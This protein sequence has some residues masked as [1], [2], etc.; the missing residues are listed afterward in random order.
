M[1]NALNNFLT[2]ITK[3]LNMQHREKG[4]IIHILKDSFAGKF[5]SIKIIPINEAEIKNVMHSLKPK[6]PSGYDEIISKILKACPSV[7]FHLLS[8]I[9]NPWFQ[10]FTVFWI[11]YVFFG[12]FPGVRLWFADI[13]PLKMELIE[14]SETSANH[15]RTPGKYPKEY[16]QYIYNHSL[17][18]VIFPDHLKIAVVIPLYKK[19]GKA[20]MTNYK[21]ISLLAVFRRVLEKAKHCRL[22]QHLH[23]NNIL[24]TQQYD[25]R[26]GISTEDAAFRLTD[27]VFECINQKMHVRGIFYDLAKAFDFVNHEILSAILPFYGTWGV[28]KDWFRFCLTNRSQQV[29]VTSPNSTQIF[30]PWLEYTEIWSSPRINS[31]ASIVHNRCKW[32]SPENKFCTRTNIIYC[33]T[34]FIISSRNFEYFCSVLNLGLSNMIKWFAANNLVL[35]LE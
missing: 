35:N 30:F 16:I 29:E 20:S 2:T 26:K 15:N 3:K 6:T 18:T 11:L 19:G 10:T 9:Y 27:S 33:F 34:S 14:G 12:Y 21:R 22:S 28:S 5:P 23:T 25:F 8:Y 13:Q 7:N 1:D 31:R 32:P 24:V 17:Y 4:D